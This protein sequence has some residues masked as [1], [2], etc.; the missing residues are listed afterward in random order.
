MGYK[1]NIL[2]STANGGE[3]RVHD[4]VLAG[5][6][7]NNANWCPMLVENARNSPYFLDLNEKAPHLTIEGIQLVLQF[8][9]EGETSITLSVFPDVLAVA[10]F[11]GITD[12]K[13]RIHLLKMKYTIY[14]I[15]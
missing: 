1:P 6:S 11:F 14:S 13:V 8:L 4:V 9:Y 10:A 15:Q 2:L 3:F 7:E 5:F 12:I